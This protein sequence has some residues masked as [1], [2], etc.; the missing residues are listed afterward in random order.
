VATVTG[1]RVVRT[2]DRGPV[3]GSAPAHPLRHPVGDRG[4]VRA[5][6]PGV[7]DDRL[8]GPW[9]LPGALLIGRPACPE[10]PIALVVHGAKRGFASKRVSW[11]T[12]PDPTLHDE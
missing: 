6:R 8:D 3:T 1:N 2:R 4:Y 12:H 11:A 9:L 5:R 7:A 10:R